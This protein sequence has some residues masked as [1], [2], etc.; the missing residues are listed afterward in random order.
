MLRRPKIT[1]TY[2]VNNLTRN[3]FKDNTFQRWGF[4]TSGRAAVPIRAKAISANT[5]HALAFKSLQMP[6]LLARAK[7]SWRFHASSMHRETRRVHELFRRIQVPV[8][9]EIR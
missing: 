1:L 5:F 2:I 3:R 7:C 4:S 6:D 9:Y 8:V